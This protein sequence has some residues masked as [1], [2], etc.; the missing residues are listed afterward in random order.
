MYFPL[1]A[2]GALYIFI[3]INA[4]ITTLREKLKKRIGPAANGHPME[5]RLKQT[6]ITP[7]KSFH[8]R[9]KLMR[10]LFFSVLW[11]LACFLPAPLLFQFN[12]KLMFGNAVRQLWVKTLLH[13]GCAWNPVSCVKI[14]G[15][16]SWED[17][18][19][20]GSAETKNATW[21]F[22]FVIKIR[23][24]KQK[25]WCEKFQRNK[26]FFYAVRADKIND[27]RSRY[28]KKAWKDWA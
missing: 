9:F 19:N 24:K 22:K 5:E 13:Y 20:Q 3:Y 26:V 17:S 27:N 14:I 2:A 28:R 6:A 18:K 11:Y 4:L 21:E 8:R 15:S 10:M 25:I 12:P 16:R 1:G 7:A 23:K